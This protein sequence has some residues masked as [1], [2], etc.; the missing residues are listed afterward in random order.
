MSNRSKVRRQAGSPHS[1]PEMRGLCHYTHPPSC[2]HVAGTSHLTPYHR[3]RPASLR[4]APCP[5]GERR[6]ETQPQLRSKRMAAQFASHHDD[7]L[8]ALSTGSSV[9]AQTASTLPHLFCLDW[10]AL[11]NAAAP[12]STCSFC[13]Q[14]SC[15]GAVLS[16]LPIFGI[17]AR[18]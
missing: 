5:F 17:C 15:P 11:W 10:H 8:A 13:Q 9:P 6:S 14:L 18:R 16:K 12:A 2:R 1:S 4:R 3:R 7:A